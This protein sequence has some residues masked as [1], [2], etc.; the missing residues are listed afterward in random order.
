[1]ARLV[2]QILE[3]RFW[4][5]YENTVPQYPDGASPHIPIPPGLR[6]CPSLLIPPTSENL[7][8]FRPGKFGSGNGANAR[9]GFALKCGFLKSGAL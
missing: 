3:I 8:G 7:H 9:Q 5:L 2:T 4:H 1:M 6:Y